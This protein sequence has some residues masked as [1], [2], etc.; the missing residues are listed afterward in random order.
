MTTTEQASILVIGT[1]IAPEHKE[2]AGEV[3]V[4]DTGRRAIEL[5]R[6][7]K[8]D[9]VVISHPLPDMPACHSIPPTSISIYNA[10]RSAKAV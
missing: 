8:F 3:M 9:L 7:L 2:M 4:A 6:M 5:L 10:F 1:D